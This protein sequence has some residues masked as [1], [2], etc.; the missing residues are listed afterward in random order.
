MGKLQKPR[1]KI[2]RVRL[3]RTPGKQGPGGKTKVT[4]KK[5]HWG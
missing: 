5:K 2:W 3:P 1:K 4:R